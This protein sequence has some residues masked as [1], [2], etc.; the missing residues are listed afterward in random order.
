MNGSLSGGQV[1]KVAGKSSDSLQ[2]VESKLSERVTNWTV[3]IVQ[4][5]I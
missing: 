4:M 1:E 3:F 5:L 2:Q